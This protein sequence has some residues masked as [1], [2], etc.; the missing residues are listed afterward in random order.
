MSTHICSYANKM[1]FMLV[2][3]LLSFLLMLF[4]FPCQYI[5]IL[6]NTQSILTMVQSPLNRYFVQ[7]RIYS[8]TLPCI[9][10][11][12][13]NFSSRDT[14]FWKKQVICP[15]KYCTFWI[16]LLLPC[17]GVSLFLNPSVWKVRSSQ[18]R[19]KLNVFWLKYI[20]H[21]KS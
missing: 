15:T 3:Q 17:G 21:M 9:W 4:T 7:T 14:D 5:F 13:V 12:P 20:C 19:L 18:Y 16:F 11:C 8:G 2:Y 1:L 10:L 6:H